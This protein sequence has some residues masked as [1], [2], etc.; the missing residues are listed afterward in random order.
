MIGI[1]PPES[2]SIADRNQ[3]VLNNL[4]IVKF[5]V[6]KIKR[7]LNDVVDKDDLISA[8]MI[9]LIDAASKF[10]NAGKTEFKTYANHRVNGAIFD[11]LRDI[12]EVPRSIRTLQKKY[13]TS[14][15]ILIKMTGREPT[16]EEIAIHL[17]VRIR[18]LESMLL[19]CFPLQSSSFCSE[20]TPDYTFTPVIADFETTAKKDVST[21]LHRSKQIL[22]ERDRDILNLIY[23]HDLN[24]R[25][26]GEKFNL[27]ESRVSQRNK[28]I[29]S[30]L[31]VQV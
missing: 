12:D 22:S 9:G 13:L 14:L 25:E 8:G 18:K 6:L 30:K 20:G 5:C 2:R 31:R 4:D 15:H 21:L 29:L 19:T 10:D 28:E 16:R 3:L 24:Y 7:H 1:T 26:V 27:S 11:S 17:N 23:W